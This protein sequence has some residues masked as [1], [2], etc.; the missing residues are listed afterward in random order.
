METEGRAHMAQSKSMAQGIDITE[1]K[2]AEEA[3]RRSEE[4]YRSILESIQEG[5]FETDLDGNYFC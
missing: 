5:Y 4:R 2:Q 1:R 3:L